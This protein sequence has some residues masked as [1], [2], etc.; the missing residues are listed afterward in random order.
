MY[1]RG[2]DCIQ[3]QKV[4]LY[5]ERT[6]DKDYCVTLVHYLNL[7]EDYE[8]DKIEVREVRSL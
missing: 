1:V 7:K 4:I 8:G 3:L 5:D 6:F 2:E